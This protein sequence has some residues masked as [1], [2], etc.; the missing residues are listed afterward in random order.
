MMP[1]NLTAG[2]KTDL[3]EFMKALTGEPPPVSL[4]V[5]ISK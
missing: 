2:D 1:L 4:V 5:D 3:V